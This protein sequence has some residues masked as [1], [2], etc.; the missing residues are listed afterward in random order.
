M[1]LL[2]HC[3]IKINVINYSMISLTPLYHRIN[4]TKRLMTSRF[5]CF[6]NHLMTKFLYISGISSSVHIYPEDLSGEAYPLNF[7]YIFIW[8]VYYLLK[9]SLNVYLIL[10]C[11]WC[12]ITC[13]GLL[14][15]LFKGWN[16]DMVWYFYDICWGGCLYY[17]LIHCANLNSI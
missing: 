12:T 9:N 3:F 13:L 8:V 10:F 5:E 15:C 11:G 4:S 1:K 2:H 17:R 14:F 16:I 7:D 6:W